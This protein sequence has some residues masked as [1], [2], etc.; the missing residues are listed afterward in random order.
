MVLTTFNGI[1][2]ELAAINRVLTIDMDFAMGDMASIL[3]LNPKDSI[4]SLFPEPTAL[5]NEC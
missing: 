5:M 3:D 1:A 2:A 4:M